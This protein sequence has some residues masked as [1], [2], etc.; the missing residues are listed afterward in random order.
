MKA[1]EV[2]DSAATSPMPGVVDRILVK[3]GD[4]VK[5][6]DPLIVIVAMKMEVSFN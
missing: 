5:K 4:F 3:S 6:G 2:S 1:S